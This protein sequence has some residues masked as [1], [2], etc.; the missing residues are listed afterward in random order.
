M[1]VC[2]RMYVSTVIIIASLTS[3]LS[4]TLVL[5]LGSCIC[6]IFCVVIFSSSLV[7]LEIIK[8]SCLDSFVTVT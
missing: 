4:I 1:C 8:L 3:I 2:A 6:T 7:M 5:G